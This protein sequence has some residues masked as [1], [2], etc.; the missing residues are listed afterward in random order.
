[1][2]LARIGENL[3]S[4]FILGGFGYIICQSLKGNNVLGKL[5]DKMGKFTGGKNKK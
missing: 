1:M 4:I 3:L 2:S 5:K